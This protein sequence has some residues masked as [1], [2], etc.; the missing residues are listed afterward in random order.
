M[1]LSC[2]LLKVVI[3]RDQEIFGMKCFRSCL[4][5][6]AH[7]CIVHRHFLIPEFH[8]D[9]QFSLGIIRLQLAQVLNTCSLVAYT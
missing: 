7:V 9:G 3:E 1:Y 8:N 6:F 5:L 4:R 2:H